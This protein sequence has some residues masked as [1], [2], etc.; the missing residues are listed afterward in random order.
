MFLVL[1]EKTLTQ[2]SKITKSGKR[3]QHDWTN[4]IQHD[5]TGYAVAGQ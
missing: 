4:L 2:K 5:C 3:S 1:A